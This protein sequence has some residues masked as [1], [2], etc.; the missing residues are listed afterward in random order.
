MNFLFPLSVTASS[1]VT[2]RLIQLY[3]SAADDFHATS[4]ALL[5]SLLGLAVLEHWFMVLPLPSEKLWSWAFKS[6]RSARGNAA[7]EREL[8][9]KAPYP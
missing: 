8:T 5:S 2:A 9:V 3:L 7:L 4:Y 6:G 1:I